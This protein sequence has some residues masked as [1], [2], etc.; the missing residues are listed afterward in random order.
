MSEYV[1][2]S[3]S[4]FKS[5]WKKLVFTGRGKMPKSVADDK[6]MVAYVASKPGAIGYVSATAD[7]TGVKKLEVK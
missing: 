3:A 2:K 7:I 1:K 6:A 5:F 4:S